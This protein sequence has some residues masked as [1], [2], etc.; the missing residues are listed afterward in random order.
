MVFCIIT[1]VPHGIKDNLFFAYSPYVREINIWIKNVEEVILVAPFDGD[2][3]SA[4]HLNYEHKKI[5]FISIPSMDLLSLISIFRSV[6]NTPKISWKI[7]QAMRNADHIHLRCPGNIGLLGCFIQILFPN[8]PKTAKYAGNWD[9]KSKQPLSY[10][11][12]RWILSNTFLTKNMQVLVY[13]EWEGSSKNIKPF[14]T[15]TYRDEDKA[16]IAPRVLK[17]TINFIFV[18]TLSEGKRPLYAVQI[19]EKLNKMGCKCILQLF[20]EGAEKQKL[21][22]YCEENKL[23]AIVYFKGNQN[24]FIVRNAYQTSHFILL[25]SQSEGWPK[26]VAEGM[27]WGCVPITTKVS[28]LG[29]M[30]DNGKR[31]VFFKMNINDDVSQIMTLINNQES[32]K[33]M[34]QQGI[35]WSRKYTLD[36]FEKE[37]KMLLQS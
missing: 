18:G 21:Q 12:Q 14:F 3:S 1:H 25:P 36:L 30:L 19:I 31:G 29:K 9:P 4:I 2:T 33:S 7:F 22:K 37:I 16:I 5:R 27:F 10:K 8:K 24:E 26:V 15:A 13:G 11:L 28:C 32:Y 20:G 34:A 17:Q 35:I 23:N 6:M